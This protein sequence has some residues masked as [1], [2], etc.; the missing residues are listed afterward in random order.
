MCGDWPRA[1]RLLKIKLRIETTHVRGGL[2]VSN[3]KCGIYRS[4]GC[5]N[6]HWLVLILAL[7]RSL[8]VCGVS[9]LY[10]KIAVVVAVVVSTAGWAWLLGV[11]IK[12]LI[13]QFR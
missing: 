4:E 8:R 9:R 13:L 12:W 5:L 3:C 1:F 7:P 10:F 6:R 11:G 2:F